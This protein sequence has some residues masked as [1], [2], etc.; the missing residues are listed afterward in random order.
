MPTNLYGEGD[1]YHQTD[2]HVVPAL[3]RRFYEATKENYEY[4]KC[5]G[6]GFPRREFLNVDDLGSASVFVLE[7]WSPIILIYPKIL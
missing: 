2:S 6:S 1:N 4:V 5:W 7:N 3:I